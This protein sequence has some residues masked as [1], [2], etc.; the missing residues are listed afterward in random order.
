[1]VMLGRGQEGVGAR[2][3]FYLGDQEW[4]MVRR[5]EAVSHAYVWGKKVP[6]EGA[7]GQRSWGRSLLVAFT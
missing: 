6:T 2:L 5:H 1:M 4:C 7:A 3:F